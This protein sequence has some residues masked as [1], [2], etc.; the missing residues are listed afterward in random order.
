MYTLPVNLLQYKHFPTSTAPLSY[1][2]GTNNGFK[3]L[4]ST[5][6]MACHIPWEQ[7]LKYLALYMRG[8]LDWLF[9]FVL[10]IPGYIILSK[11][12]NINS[13]DCIRDFEVF[14]FS[15]YQKITFH[16]PLINRK[17]HWEG[18][19]YDNS[20]INPRV[21]TLR[22]QTRISRL[23]F[24]CS[25]VIRSWIGGTGLSFVAD[26]ILTL[27]SLIPNFSSLQSFWTSVDPLS[28]VKAMH[29]TISSPVLLWKF[30]VL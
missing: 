29:N 13:Y 16:K 12:K 26:L 28:S 18:L 22:T 23:K 7:I 11:K 6:Y 15:F 30:T 9:L 19:S 14:F 5:I 8:C 2:E 21:P 27:Q 20:N 1:P 3:E 10:W 4:H 17:L 24:G 25:A